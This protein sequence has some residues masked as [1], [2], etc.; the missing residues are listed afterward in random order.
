MSSE[1]P[2]TK[3]AAPATRSKRELTRQ[4]A[5]LVVAALVVLFAVLNLDKVKVNWILGT[6]STPL[7]IVIA[8]SFLFGVAG[9]YL[10]RGRRRA[11]KEQ[12]R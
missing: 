1:H 4:V 6:W 5:A 7:I 10:L 3:P 8:I 9:G 11:G 2:T 12:R